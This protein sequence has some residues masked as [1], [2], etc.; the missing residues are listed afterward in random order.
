MALK[1]SA[2]VKRAAKLVA[3]AK[4]VV[5][6]IGVSCPMTL[7]RKRNETHEPSSHAPVAAPVAALLPTRVGQAGVSVSAG[8]PDFRS[9]VSCPAYFVAVYWGKGC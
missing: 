6:L 2:A 8:I 1:T 3:E 7:N 9:P 4:N 5:L